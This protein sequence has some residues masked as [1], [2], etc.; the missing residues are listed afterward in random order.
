MSIKKR[1]SLI[2]RANAWHLILL[3]LDTQKE[4]CLGRIDYLTSACASGLFVEGLIHLFPL[5]CRRSPV[6]ERI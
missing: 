4:K 5:N 1:V 2:I 3:C 6:C